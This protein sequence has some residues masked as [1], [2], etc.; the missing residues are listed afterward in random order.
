MSIL[1]KFI[2][3]NQKVLIKS[4]LHIIY[5]F[6]HGESKVDTEH[7]FV[8]IGNKY[9]DIFFGYYDIT[10]FN[11]RGDILYVKKDKGALEVSICIN[12]TSGKNEHILA[13]S[14]AWNWQQGCRL[15]WFPK[16]EDEIVFNIFENDRYFAR[17]I[18][19]MGKIVREYSY[20][21][22]DIDRNGEVGLS[23]NFE[24]LGVLRPGYGY[25]CRPYKIS[26]L[27]QE[28]IYILNL[29][30]DKIIDSVTYNDI[31]QS[32]RG[33]CDL[34][35]CYI[36]HLS[37]SPN[38]KQFLFFWI[39]IKNGYHQASLLIYRIDERK[40]VALDTKNKASHYVWLDEN[41]ILC[42]S[43]DSPSSCRYYVY[44]VDKQIKVPYCVK[45]L[46]E[47]GHP[48]VLDDNTIITDTYPNANGNQYIYKVDSKNDTKEQIIRIYSKPV[49]NGEWRTDLHPRFNKDKTK[50]CFDSNI[51]GNRELFIL[52]FDKHA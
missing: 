10:P 18:D 49:T 44:Y 22:Y 37:F 27:E 21:L 34:N 15:R 29:K 9:S 8:I 3:P 36:N 51:N 46:R 17:V 5:R 20:P 31:A 32:L 28:S 43:Y 11:S 52:E 14:C 45:S 24:R 38:G 48:S 6:R 1:R 16:T 23:L 50:I 7:Q 26:K 47:D 41:R 30:E 39:E 2:T 25:T 33:K 40:L 35:K 42:T 12:T 13:K 4:V 19:T